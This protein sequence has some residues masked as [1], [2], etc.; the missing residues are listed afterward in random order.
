MQVAPIA[1]ASRLVCVNGH[2]VDEVTDIPTR[3]AC[4]S[5][6]LSVPVAGIAAGNA[7]L[8][9]QVPT[10]K[11]AQE[12]P[13]AMRAIR[14]ALASLPQTGLARWLGRDPLAMLPIV[15][16]SVLMLGGLFLRRRDF[17]PRSRLSASR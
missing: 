8:A 7:S 6:K 3:A 2:L 14:D 12:P 11:R 10:P 1:G 9:G 16:G 5:A 17:A 4:A 15:V 13:L